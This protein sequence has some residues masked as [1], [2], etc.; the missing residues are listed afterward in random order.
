MEV[1]MRFDNQ[2]DDSATRKLL[3]LGMSLSVVLGIVVGEVFNYGDQGKLRIISLTA[4]GPLADGL[5]LLLI[6]LII[7]GA[8][9]K[10][11]TLKPV[12]L[13]ILGAALALVPFLAPVILSLTSPHSTI[14]TQTGAA[15]L[16]LSIIE[17]LGACF[18]ASGLRRQLSLKKEQ[19]RRNGH[20]E[21]H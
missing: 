16:F 20:K 6:M 4:R 11:T 17:V 2:R 7:F 13:I 15:F 19:S 9:G 14:N 12:T 18:L 3:W 21:Q 8:V 5:A 10:S 1:A